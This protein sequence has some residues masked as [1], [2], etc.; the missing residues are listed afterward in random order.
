MWLGR[1]SKNDCHITL[2][3][4]GLLHTRTVKRV[5][6][7]EKKRPELYNSGF[8]QGP[9]QEEPVI[10]L[11]VPVPRGP[12]DPQVIGE[13]LEGGERPKGLLDF[14]R[15]KRAAAGEPTGAAPA[16]SQPASGEG[17]VEAPLPGPVSPVGASLA[18][19]SADFLSTYLPYHLV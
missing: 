11:M 8:F 10:P 6:E 14:L 1:S 19:G 13:D 15:R 4:E 12:P 17:S 18:T 2:T 5:D 7:P 3:S 9:F 16:P